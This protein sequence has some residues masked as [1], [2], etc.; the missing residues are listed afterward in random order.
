VREQ[1]DAELGLGRFS[2][3]DAGRLVN[4]RSAADVMFRPPSDANEILE[5]F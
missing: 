3:S 1:L 4:R 5:L 2:V